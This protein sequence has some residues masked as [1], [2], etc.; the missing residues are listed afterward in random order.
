MRTLAARLPRVRSR[1]RRRRLAAL[2]AVPLAVRLV[3]GAVLV[4]A[5]WLALNWLYQVVRKPTELYAAVGGG[6][7]KT[8]RETWGRYGG[9][10]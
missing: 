6:V 7:A 5:V 1:R 3:V 4:L 9:L 2:L 10:F 8:P